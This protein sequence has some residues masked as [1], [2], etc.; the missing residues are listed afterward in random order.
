MRKVNRLKLFIAL[1]CCLR[2]KWWFKVRPN[3]KSN[4]GG[5]PDKTIPFRCL[6]CG[7]NY[8]V[9]EKGGGMKRI[10]AANHMTVKLFSV[11][12]QC[13]IYQ[14]VAIVVFTP[15]WWLAMFFSDPNDLT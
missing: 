13:L 3:T 4:F 11:W 9:Q 10:R 8:V 15:F 12:N 14:K 1:I 5:T 6:Y 7:C 2:C